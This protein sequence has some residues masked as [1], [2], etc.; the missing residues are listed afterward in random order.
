MAFHDIWHLSQNVINMAIWVSK[1]PPRLGDL[2][3]KLQ[4]SAYE[5]EIFR[6]IKIT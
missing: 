4:K 2:I 5:Y 3:Q 1:E 6:K